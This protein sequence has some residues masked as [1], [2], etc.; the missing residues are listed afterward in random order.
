MNTKAIAL[1]IAIIVV[2]GGA[3]YFTR[4]NSSD[5]V[6][7]E[8]KNIDSKD[9]ISDQSEAE[10]GSIKSL[11]DGGKNKQCNFTTT[12][13]KSITS[14]VIYVSSEKKMRGDFNVE[15]DNV[16][17]QTHMLN[18]GTTMY[19][20]SD[21]TNHGFKMN[22]D[23]LEAKQPPQNS[24]GMDLNQDVKFDCKSWTVDQSKFDVPAG[25]NF[26]EMPTLPPSA[27][28]PTSTDTKAVQQAMCNNLPEPSKSQCLAG[29]K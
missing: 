16:T 2:A 4:N 26:D 19:S 12:N 20:W 18:D 29:L 17:M 23:A 13:E 11:I 5:R 22:L 28:I 3:F 15:N 10:T 14:G 21:G 24:Q 8:T 1:I 9:Q 27:N 7:S 25:V 6:A